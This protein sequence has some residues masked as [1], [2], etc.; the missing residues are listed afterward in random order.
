M[1]QVSM[2]IPLTRDGPWPEHT[3]DPQKIK[4]LPAFDP[5]IFYLIRWDF[6]DSK[7]KKLK[8]L[9]F[10]RENFQIQH[11]AQASK[12]LPSH[13]AEGLENHNRLVFKAGKNWDFLKEM[14]HPAEKNTTIMAGFMVKD[15]HQIKLSFNQILF[16]SS[17]DRQCW[18]WSFLPSAGHLW[19]DTHF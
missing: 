10:L 12:K 1:A 2:V 3:L 17:W 18:C 15:Q 4:G 13:L 11:L 6:F 14:P 9:V 5:G 7:N 19:N 16:P 8:K